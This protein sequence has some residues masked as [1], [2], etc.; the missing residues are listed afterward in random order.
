MKALCLSGGGSHGC[1]AIGFLKYLI[2]DLNRQYDILTGISVGSLSAAFLSQY[3]K[4]QE[5]EALSNLIDIWM[6]IGTNDIRK[7]WTFSYVQGFFKCSMFD[8]SPLKNLIHNNLDINKSRSS[9]RKLFIGAVNMTS[10]LYEVFTEKDDIETAILCSSSYPCALEPVKFNNQIYSDGGL[11]HVMDIKSAILA[12][13]TEI[14]ILMCSPEH[15]TAKYENKNLYEFG[16][17]AVDIMTDSL[18]NSDLK[19]LELYN[20][21]AL[22]GT[23]HD[24]KYIKYNLI[25]PKE[26]INF[27]P[28]SFDHNDILQMIELGYEI[29]KNSGIE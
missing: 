12:G 19:L 17:R 22:S 28:L 27:S 5:K 3:P 13:A 11:S 4:E 2:N 10:G 14:D 23:R 24:K 7:Q 9:G 21:L 29:A 26:T 20:Q 25:R 18:I 15:S 16:T 1:V 8:S 6:K